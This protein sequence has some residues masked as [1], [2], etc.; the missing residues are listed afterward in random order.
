M[1]DFLSLPIFYSIA[2]A[3]IVKYFEI[4]IPRQ[5]EIPLDHIAGGMVSIAL[6][7]LGSQLSRSKFFDRITPVLVT[8]LVRFVLS[9]VIALL[10]CL[11]IPV[12]QEIKNMLILVSSLP[13]AVNV[14]ILA[15]ETGKDPE[16]ASQMV[17]WSTVVSAL[18]VPILIMLL[19]SF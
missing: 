3:L 15:M 13:V 12:S 5:V 2:A 18:A 19:E 1:R 16:L 8:L 7:T 17:F 14:N 4:P 6:L 9:P 10:V 11:L